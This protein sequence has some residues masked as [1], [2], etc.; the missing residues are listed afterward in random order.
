MT[1]NVPALGGLVTV[2]ALTWAKIQA[3]T[4]FPYD[5]VQHCWKIIEA[6]TTRPTLT[7]EQIWQFHAKYGEAPLMRVVGAIKTVSGMKERL[8]AVEPIATALAAQ[9]LATL[10]R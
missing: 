10:N 8:R 5:P 7:V 2:K 4:P 1:I 9:Y 6:A 3:L